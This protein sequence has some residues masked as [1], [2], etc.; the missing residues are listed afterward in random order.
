MPGCIHYLHGGV[1]TSTRF[2]GCALWPRNSPSLCV[3]PECSGALSPCASVHGGVSAL[4]DHRGL[5]EHGGR[6]PPHAL[7]AFS[8]PTIIRLCPQGESELAR[9]LHPSPARGP[10]SGAHRAYLIVSLL[11][12]IYHRSQLGI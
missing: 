3:T 9:I 8:R 4:F 12:D 6:R 2:C 5:I 11:R 7:G 10:M 1:A